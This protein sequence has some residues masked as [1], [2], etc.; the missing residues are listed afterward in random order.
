MRQISH[1]FGT[2]N[3]TAIR[4]CIRDHII[5]PHG[6]KRHTATRAN[7]LRN[8]HGSGQIA[9]QTLKLRENHAA[10]SYRGSRNPT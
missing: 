6:K 4:A 1:P 5:H 7:M 9:L 8:V 10:D 2:L 3:H